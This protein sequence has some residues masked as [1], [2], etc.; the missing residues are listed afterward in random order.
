VLSSGYRANMADIAATLPEPFRGPV[1]SGIGQTLAVA[2]QL[3][4]RATAVVGAARQAFVDGWHQAM[5]V[6]AGMAVLAIVLLVVRGPKS[7]PESAPVDDH[8]F[9]T[10]A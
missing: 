4:D 2:P 5:W 3:G 1:E 9:A 6:G 7:A 8:Q 10:V